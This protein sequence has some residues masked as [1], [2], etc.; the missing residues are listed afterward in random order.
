M[1]TRTIRKTWEVGG[2]LT[3]LEGPDGIVLSD[4]AS[5]FGVQRNDTKETVVEVDTPMTRVSTGVYEYTFTEPAA[6]L[7]YTAWV[8]IVYAG[9]TYHFS[10]E[11]AAPSSSEMDAHYD[12]IRREIGRFL[13]YDRAPSSWTETQAL[14]IADI[15][16]SG[17]RQ[18]MVPPVLSG[19]RYSHEWSFLRPITPLTLTADDGVY[20]L[21]AGFA[22]LD[23]PLTLVI[24]DSVEARRVNVTAEW[25]VRQLQ[26]GSA[27]TGWPELAA[28]RPKAHDATVGTRYELLLYPIP[29]GAYQLL[30]PYRVGIEFL[31]STNVYPPGGEVHA[32][33]ILESCREAG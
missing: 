25:K 9:V 28:I 10:I 5:A 20:D 8:E 19:E 27:P 24:S 29:D 31:D 3:D 26:A 7:D 33:T 32:E 23:G 18:F 12:L 15:I 21:P 11:L 4:P 13:G 2:V 1:S 16:K 6:G 30:I 17:L 14:D 22:M